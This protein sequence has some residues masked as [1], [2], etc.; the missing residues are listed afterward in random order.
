[1]GAGGAYFVD[2]DE[3]KYAAAGLE[4][5][6]S[7][8]W[9]RPMVNGFPR[10]Q[11][12]PLVYWLMQP[13]LKAAMAWG[14]PSA[15]TPLAARTPSLLAAALVAVFTAIMG[16]RLLGARAGLAAGL[17]LPASAVFHVLSHILKVDMVFAAAMAAASCG[18]VFRFKGEARGWA[19]ALILVGLGVGGLAKGPFIYV[20]LAAY[21]AAL[22]SLGL[23]EQEFDWPDRLRG[24]GRNLWAERWLLAAGI[25]AGAAPL[26]AW[27]AA[28]RLVG[29][30]DYASAFVG[31]FLK[32]SS[33]G[34][35]LDPMHLLSNPAFYLGFSAVLGLFPWGGWLPGGSVRLARHVGER[36]G[37]WI[38]LLWL[39]I[40]HVLLGVFVF[41]LRA[42]RYFLPAFP[43]FALMIADFL[44][45]PERGRLQRILFWAGAGLG[46]ATAVAFAL[47]FFVVGAAP[48]NL[49]EGCP[50]DWSSGPAIFLTAGGVLLLAAMAWACRMQS[51]RPYV[52]VWTL[53][54]CFIVGS[55][56]YAN[57]FPN[58]VAPEDRR[59]MLA[60]SAAQI[61]R[62][63][64][65]EALIVHTDSLASYYPGLHYELAVDRAAGRVRYT[66]SLSGKADQGLAVTL[67][68]PQQT[69]ELAALSRG[70]GS[71][72]AAKY[73]KGRRFRETA[74]LLTGR[75]GVEL[76][77][78]LRWME[79]TLPVRIEYRCFSGYS[80]KWMNES[81]CLVRLHP[82]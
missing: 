24:A 74:L 51:G 25:A 36:D 46:L 64:G 42:H 28:A 26:A 9:L 11:K 72:P 58:A 48:I 55:V 16:R 54:A 27:L 8:D 34:A 63:L 29:G 12:P 68:R 37:A 40:L 23:L 5:A 80:L 31:Q 67:L 75:E 60:S 14:G 66:A 3:P 47:R 13:A 49:W 7:G 18:F 78:W 35:G 56:L 45:S 6:V 20:S 1:V 2:I 44:F 71:F 52:H 70:A 53:A 38:F 33:A 76:Q 17:I 81:M 21:A 65:P 41:R 61:L 69:A 4:M 19:V 77:P 57:L 82:G 32:N 79:A 59:S 50:V 22:V 30:V 39:A 10:L 43:V 62:S 15:V 73:F